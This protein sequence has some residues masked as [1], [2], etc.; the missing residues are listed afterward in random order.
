MKTAVVLSGGGTRGAYELG[1]WRAFKELGIEYQI[2]TGTSIG[3]I[4]GA[5]M[6]IGNYERTEEMWLGLKMTD[7]LTEKT[8]SSVGKKIAGLFGFGKKSGSSD[9]RLINGA[10][11]NSPFANFISTWIEEDKMRKSPIDYGLVTVRMKDRK[12]FMLSKD[13]IPQGKMQDYVTA[14][15]SVFPIFPLHQI[16]GDYY[17]DGC[18]HDNLPIDLAIRMGAEHVIVVDLHVTPQHANYAERPYTTY[19]TPSEDTGPVLGFDPAKIRYNIEMGYRDAMRTFGKFKG[20][21]YYFK[22]DGLKDFDAAMD[23]F[24][25][26][27]MEAEAAIGLNVQKKKKK[28]KTDRFRLFKMFSEYARG[29]GVTKEDYFIRGAEITA[30]VFGLDHTKIWEM[31]DFVKEAFEKLG[32]E[33]KYPEASSLFDGDIKQVINR[34]FRIKTEKGNDALAGSIYY[35]IAKR[36]PDYEKVSNL[37]S[38]FPE[39]LAVQLFL[40]SVKN[41]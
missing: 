29:R 1:A 9:D 26:G 17:I 3:S 4:N 34:L 25:M 8:G 18:Y 15:A 21:L 39:E 11:D 30:D 23:Y 10:V 32:P 19:I 6:C 33:S 36:E 14:S 28:Q 38:Y 7:M 40:N 37:L 20:F 16:D 13:E 31:K 12:P 24:S 27:C 5:M 41:I 35:R 2:V 22:P